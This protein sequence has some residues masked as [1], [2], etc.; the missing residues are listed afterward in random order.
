M[1][2]SALGLVAELLERL[3]DPDVRELEV[4]QGELRVKVSRDGVPSAMPAEV[5]SAE[6]AAPS[7][8]KAAPAAAAKAAASTITAPL[9]G[10][11]YR[12]VSPQAPPFVQVGTVVSPGDVIGLIEAMKLF[13]EVRSTA[14]G[15]VRRLVAENGQL[16]R[17]HQPL[18]ELE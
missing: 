11:F 14:A 4:R 8:A 13:N 2:E 7:G 16:V 10:I 9:T 6:P 12:S 18:L 3:R 1:R 15:R 5:V 17:A